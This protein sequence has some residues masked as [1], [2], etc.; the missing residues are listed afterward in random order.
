MNNELVR[1]FHFKW[2]RFEHQKTIGIILQSDTINFKG[3]I[4][5]IL[6]GNYT[7]VEITD[8]LKTLDRMV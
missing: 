6:K 5:E 2:Y 3:H 8:Q 1:L 7:S 4:L